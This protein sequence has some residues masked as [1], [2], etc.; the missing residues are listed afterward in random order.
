[1]PTLD[2]LHARLAAFPGAGLEHPFGPIP[3]VYKVGG[4]MFAIVF[5]TDEGRRISLKCDPDLAEILRDA[6][7]AVK[8][9]Y[10]ANK[11]H[12]NTVWLDEPLPD[13][14]LWNMIEASYELV[15]GRLPKAGRA[16]LGAGG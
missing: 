4:K 9:G 12:W 15:R 2:E 10:H 14:V 5:S 13:D 8:P 3:A 6:Y 1:M 11:R 7:P 16:K